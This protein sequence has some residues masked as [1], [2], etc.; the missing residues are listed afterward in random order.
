MEVA[1]IFSVFGLFV[2]WWT[3]GRLHGVC[4]LLGSVGFIYLGLGDARLDR[5]L[6][7]HGNNACRGINASALVLLLGLHNIHAGSHQI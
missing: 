2:I 7:W 5:E 6:A 1:T 4:F 3:L